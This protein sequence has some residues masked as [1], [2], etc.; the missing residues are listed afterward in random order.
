VLCRG[1]D[2]AFASV[3]GPVASVISKTYIA[4]F[5]LARRG[6]LA[7]AYASGIRVGESSVRGGRIFL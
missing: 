3:Y 1:A 6:D 5:L 2:L 4:W 7:F